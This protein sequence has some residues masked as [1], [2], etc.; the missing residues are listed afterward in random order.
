MSAEADNPSGWFSAEMQRL[1]RMGHDKESR[2]MYLDGTNLKLEGHPMS[3][4]GTENLAER[5]TR[6][7]LTAEKVRNGDMTA[8]EL[9]IAAQLT[10]IGNALDIIFIS[11]DSNPKLL[12][13]FYRQLALMERAS[14]HPLTLKVIEAVGEV[15]R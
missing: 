10:N 1:Y 9:Q 6:E 13:T 8:T 11:M 3:D 15:D 14:L 4:E 2:A 12:R 7:V 5:T